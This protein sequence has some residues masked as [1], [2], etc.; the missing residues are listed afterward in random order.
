MG[1]ERAATYGLVGFLADRI[2]G[3]GALG[4]IAASLWGGL[5]T[6]DAGEMSTA[7]D[8][9]RATLRD[10]VQNFGG[11]DMSQFS[12]FGDVKDPASTKPNR[13]RAEAE[14]TRRDKKEGGTN[15]GKLLLGAGAAWL[16]VNVLDNVL[17]G[18]FS[19][20]WFAPF[21][22]FGFNGIQGGFNSFGMPLVGGL[23]PLSMGMGFN[24]G[25]GLLGMVANVLGL[26]PWGIMC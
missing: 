7:Y 24:R 4:T 12:I 22:N 20:G 9:R 1:I 8:K 10:T 13:A 23:D 18:P 26:N 6:P 14:A 2:L 3:T 5:M 17:S 19:G 16:G 11:F 25:G 21:G 15:W